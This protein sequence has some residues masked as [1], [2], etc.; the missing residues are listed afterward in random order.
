SPFER[1]LDSVHHLAGTFDHPTTIGPYRIEREL[2]RGGMGIVFLAARDDDQY[3]KHV[4]VKVVRAG[5]DTAD[6]VR[7]F[8]HGR[9]TLANLEHPN[10]AR[11]L[12]GG[13]TP[14]GL[15]YFVMEYVVGERIDHYCD[16]RQPTIR[17]RV[18]LC[19]SVCAA[20]QY[21]HRSLIVH[22]DLKPD[23]ILV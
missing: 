6:I 3:V 9:Q 7:R 12:D 13:M 15:P 5:V 22:R 20:V 17:E 2:G 21:A 14:E 18:A 11:L 8:R 23:N 10:I 4:A 16:E 1:A 19:R